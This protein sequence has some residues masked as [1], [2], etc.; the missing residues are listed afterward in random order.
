MEL[1]G[2]ARGQQAAVAAA[3]N[4]QLLLDAIKPHHRRKAANQSRLL[5]NAPARFRTP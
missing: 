2:P 4:A 5:I 3:H 1:Q